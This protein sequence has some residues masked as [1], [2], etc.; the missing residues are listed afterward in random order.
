MS[1]ESRKESK[2]YLR[3]KEN[4]AG[5]EGTFDFFETNSC[6]MTRPKTN[7]MKESSLGKLGQGEFGKITELQACY[8]TFSVKCSR[9]SEFTYFMSYF[10]GKEDSM[11][12]TDAPNSIFS[13][14]LEHLAITSRTM[15][16]F[17]ALY[18]DG[19]S[20]HLMTHCLITDFS[21]TLASGGNGV[22]DATFNGICNLHYDNSG[23]IT[24]RSAPTND[25]S[26]GLYTTTVTAE[27]LINYKGCQIFLGTATEAVPLVH[28]NISYGATDLANSVD[29][30][31]YINSIT[32]TGNNGVTGEDAMRAG[33][34]GVLNNQER[35][36][37]AFT[38]E[39]NLRK[40]DT[41]P[42]T[43]FYSLIEGNT[44]RAI[45]IDWR[46]KIIKDALRY[47]MD[48]FFPVVQ[49]DDVTEDDES[50]INQ[51]IPCIVHQD[52]QGLAFAT[53]VQSKVGIRYNAC[54]DT[55]VEASSSQSASDN[56]SSGG[57]SESS[58]SP[59]DD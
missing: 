41:T 38:L 14:K 31:S 52:T 44:Q 7:W 9:L 37:F 47:G 33:G 39:L 26:S 56:S 20:T 29:I 49:I 17:T 59:H 23:T 22:I 55:S 53:Y 24:K 51:S 19:S 11:R 27:P 32:V 46:G 42:S 45:E 48:M 21:F 1:T 28:A 13:H 30:T 6:V 43:S 12:T 3:S 50:P 35:K 8:T 4:T 34:G 15:P 18:P 5:T 10:L 40:D 2:L 36:D 58:S 54:H 16:T 57:V 25:W